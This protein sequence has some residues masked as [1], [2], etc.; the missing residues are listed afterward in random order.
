VNV[1]MPSKGSG[2]S[3]ISLVSSFSTY[4]SVELDEMVVHGRIVC[5]SKV[6]QVN[7][8]MAESIY[9]GTT[10]AMTTSLISYMT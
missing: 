4:A 5:W 6:L 8:M 1:K 3:L 10:A 7:P 9:T 2:Y